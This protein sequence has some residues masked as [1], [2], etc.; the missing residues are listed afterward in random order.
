M[1]IFIFYPKWRVTHFVITGCYNK[2]YNKSCNYLI[3]SKSFCFWRLFFAKN[4]V[5][6]NPK[7][8][9]RTTEN[10]RL[11]DFVITSVITK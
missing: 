7:S 2:C 3:Y 9:N 11:I 4:F 8:K 1:P 10:Q 6:T 5:I